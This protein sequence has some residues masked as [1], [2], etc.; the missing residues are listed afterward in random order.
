MNYQNLIGHAHIYLETIGNLLETNN[1]VTI[2]IDKQGN[3]VC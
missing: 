1:D 3:Q 2:L